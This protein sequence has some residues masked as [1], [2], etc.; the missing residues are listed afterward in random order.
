MSADVFQKCVYFTTVAK[1]VFILVV[2]CAIEELN[3]SVT[4]NVARIPDK[5][6]ELPVKVLRTVV[7]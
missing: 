1:P 7:R 6:S 5:L 3:H 2:R 4:P